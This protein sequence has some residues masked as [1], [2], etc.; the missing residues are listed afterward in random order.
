MFVNVRSF[1][2]RQTDNGL[3]I[4][5]Q[6]RVKAHEDRTPYELPGGRIN[7]YESLI[8]GLKRE[9]KEETGLEVIKVF[10]EHTKVETCDSDTN[11]EAL[12]AFAVYQT[13]KGP[14][15]SLGFYF[16]CQAEGTLLHHGDQTEEVQWISVASLANKLEQ[17][18]LEFSW[19]DKAGLIYYLNWLK[20]EGI[21]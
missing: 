10:D 8:D 11:V 2:E 20:S 13:T 9:V 17:H 7:E 19:V 6:K 14:V 21:L 18:E 15:D 12:K 4:I 3:E 16:R 1:I 5:I